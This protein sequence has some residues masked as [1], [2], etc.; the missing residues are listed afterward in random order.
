MRH[1]C[2]RPGTP[3]REENF[4]E[5]ANNFAQHGH[6]MSSTAKQLAK[7]GT[8]H[9]RRTIEEIQGSAQRVGLGTLFR[10]RSQFLD[11]NSS[12]NCTSI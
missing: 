8:C 11:E 4:E 10:I 2:F 1:P 12:R 6:K 3:R 5:K 9:D 7:A